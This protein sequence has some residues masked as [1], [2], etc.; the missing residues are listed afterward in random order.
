MTLRNE[1][2]PGGRPGAGRS[3]DSDNHSVT[4]RPDKTLTFAQCLD[5]LELDDD[6]LLSF[7]TQSKGGGD[8]S[9][10][11]YKVGHLKAI[12]VSAY[13]DHNVWCGLQPMRKAVA[14]GKNSDVVRIAAL[15]ADLDLDANKIPTVDAIRR[16]IDGLSAMLAAEPSYI[17]F[18]GHGYQPVWKVDSDDSRDLDVMMPMLKGWGRLVKQVATVHGGSADSVFDPA[19][20]LRVPDTTNWKNVRV[21]VGTW[22][23]VTLP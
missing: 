2:A 17:T 8:F 11:Q 22:A 18:S 6:E 12:D 9:G 13:A 21:P 10:R 14:R 1:P 20:I 16:V 5:L 4:P 7:G 3:C 23:A 19:R 15:Y